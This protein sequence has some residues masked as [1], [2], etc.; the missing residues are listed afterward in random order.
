MKKYLSKY[1]KQIADMKYFLDVYY[2]TYEI[3]HTNEKQFHALLITE[4]DEYVLLTITFSNNGVTGGITKPIDYRRYKA[5]LKHKN[6]IY[7]DGFEYIYTSRF[8][9]LDYDDSH[10]ALEMAVNMLL[11]RACRAYGLV[12]GA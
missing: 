2:E 9:M 1:K 8:K 6:T 12:M 10:E 5:W 4:N 11:M 3:N 7:D